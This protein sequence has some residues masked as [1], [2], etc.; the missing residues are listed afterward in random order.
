MPTY[1]MYIIVICPCFCR[2]IIDVQF[3]KTT[4]TKKDLVL[5]LLVERERTLTGTVIYAMLH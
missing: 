1:V 4:V 5:R 2:D 3:I